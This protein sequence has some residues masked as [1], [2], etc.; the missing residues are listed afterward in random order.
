MHMCAHIDKWIARDFDY[1][2]L[3]SILTTKVWPISIAREEN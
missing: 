1:T 2:C 3:E